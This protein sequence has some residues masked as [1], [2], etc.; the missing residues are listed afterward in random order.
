MA[1][2]YNKWVCL[3]EIQHPIENRYAM[4]PNFFVLCC[5]KVRGRGMQET[6][7]EGGDAESSKGL[8][9][10]NMSISLFLAYF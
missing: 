10:I 9:Y 7:E 5:A 2:Q 3:V 6:R 4:H 8:R 1:L